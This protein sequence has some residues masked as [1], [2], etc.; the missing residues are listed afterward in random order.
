MTDNVLVLGTGGRD[1]ALAARYAESPHVGKAFIAP[2][3]PGITRTTKAKKGHLIVVPDLHEFSDISAFC[4][5]NNISHVDVGPEDPLNRGVVDFLYEDGIR[6]LGPTK[7]YAQLESDRAFTHQFLLDAGVPLPDFA[8]FDNSAD[9]LNYART[10]GYRVVVKANGPAAGKGTFVCD[11]R[12]GEDAER[13]IKIIMKDRRFDASGDRV[14]VEKREDGEELSFF[15]YLDGKHVLP[16]TGYAQD[17]PEAFD[18]DDSRGMFGFSYGF[19]GKGLRRGL[20]ELGLDIGIAEQAPER[21]VQ[22]IDEALRESR[23]MPGNPNT[24]G[25]G[26]FYPHRLWSEGLTDRIIAEIVNPTANAIYNKLG[27]EYRGVLYFG[28]NMDEYGGLKVFEINVR[29]GDPEMEVIGRALKTDQFELASATLNGTLNEIDQVWNGRHYADVVAVVGNSDSSDGR[30]PGYP[31]RYGLGYRVTGTEDMDRGIAL[32]YAG[33]G[34]K[35]G[36]LVTNSGRVLHVVAGGSSAREARKSAYS[37]ISKI[38]FLDENGKNHLRFRNTIG[39][40]YE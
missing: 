2:G 17:Y 14:V 4:G 40:G 38:R 8:V 32:F 27:W 10:V 34:E 21:R 28:L 33:V 37:N 13:A 3:N 5:D 36:N 25:M 1:H 9:A 6:A 22:M 11:D 24:G 15:A 26:S 16:L 29:H 35:D 7:K 39:D 19:E 30:R 31:G 23:K 12:R 20:N 18:P